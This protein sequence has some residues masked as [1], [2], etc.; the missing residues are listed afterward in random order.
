[1]DFFLKSLL[2][3]LQYCFCF[4]FCFFCHKA[5]RISVPHQGLNM[6]P[7]HLE[8]KPYPLGHQGNHWLSTF[9]HC[10]GCVSS[11]S[12]VQFFE[13]PWTRAHQSLLSMGFP[14]QEYRSELPLLSPKD[15]PD[16]RIQLRS[17]ALA[18]RFFTTEPAE[19]PYF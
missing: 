3:L 19:K 2:N 11:L 17:P 9:N 16:P 10:C 1:M 5:W 18:S 14:R 4:M 7:L 6:H 12:R 13:I 15:L 8:A